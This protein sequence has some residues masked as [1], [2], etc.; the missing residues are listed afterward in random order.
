M[1][2]RFKAYR[3]IPTPSAPSHEDTS[4]DANRRLVIFVSFAPSR[5]APVINQIDRQNFPNF[6]PRV[7]V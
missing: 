4:G 6:R 3:P 7:P 5:V 2:G 1:S